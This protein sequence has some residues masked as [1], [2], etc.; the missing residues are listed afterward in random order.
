MS[1][2]R[3][4]HLIFGIF[5]LFAGIYGIYDEV[6]NVVDFLKGIIQPLLIIFGA[7]FTFIGINRKSNQKPYIFF[8]VVF[9]F[10]GLYGLYDEWYCVMDFFKGSYPPIIIVLGTL[11][12]I[13]GIKKLKS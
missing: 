6:F 7:L 4:F 9:L 13:T 5:M 12:L 10:V 8:G 3:K 2:K 1:P 11:A